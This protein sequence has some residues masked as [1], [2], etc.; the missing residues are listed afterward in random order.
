ML[1][2]MT[3]R[4]IALI[5]HL[6]VQFYKGLHVLTGETGAGKSIVVD[7][8][9]LMLGE[10]ADRGLIRTG[11]DKGT[12][13]AVFD[14]SDCPQV[15]DVL[16]AEAL[17]AD[18]D[19]ITVMREIST[20]DRNVC[21]VCG[22]IVPLNFLKQLS[23]F[24]VDI[25]GQHEHQSLLSEKNHLGF[26][27]SFGDEPHQA[28]MAATDQAC[29]AWRETSTAF[30]ALRKENAQREERME[31]IT[32]RSRELDAAKLEIG[33]EAKLTQQRA[34][35]ADAEKINEAISAAYASLT[36]TDTGR[37]GVTALLREAQEQ[38][39]RITEYDPRFQ[40]L[41]ERLSSAF[42]EAEEMGIELRDALEGESFDPEKN[43]QILARLDTYRRLEKRYGMEA[44]ELV[45]Y[46]ERLKD[47][48]K[49]LKSMDDRLHTA[50]V[51]FKAKLAEYRQAAHQLTESRKTLA[52]HFETLMENQLK[53]LGMGST[54]FECV[55][56]EPNPDQKRV[57]SIH[58]DDHVEFFI[59]PNVG[60]PL[61]PLS[62]TA[63][64]GELSRI[65]LAMKAA[66][67]DRN[68][69]PTMIF[70]E[71]DTGISGHIASVVAEK[72]DDIARYHQVICV[73]HLA[74]IASMGDQQYLVQKQVVGER[75]LTTV[76]EMTPEQRVLEIA[77]LVGADEQHQESGLAHARAM[78][79]AAWERKHAAP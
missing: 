46:A 38:M 62:K 10:R 12:V 53:D 3:V 71:I 69:I 32:A 49:S 42:Y 56:E 60:E 59:A 21:R 78:L 44:D 24:L 70:D 65:M 11:C 15:R 52:K 54:H 50:E 73:T 34:K 26:L 64:G 14:I 9:N 2:S 76:E 68:M 66:A 36:A 31:F 25:H 39:R 40:A 19:T 22:V 55:F 58:G 33:E 8:I 17:E 37:L 6:D 27:D 30:S 1:V 23:G 79:S 43:E 4:N 63:S 29:R 77:R 61:K 48:V 16:A 47:E 35:M 72:M 41:A 57:P 13:E 7:S 28:L 75:T 45:D 74:Q 18:G 20:A 67:A 51:A 5:E